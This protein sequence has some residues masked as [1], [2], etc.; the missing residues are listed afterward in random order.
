[1]RVEHIDDGVVDRLF[2]VYE[3]SMADLA[4]G[5]ASA[6]EMRGEYRAFLEEFVSVPGQ[7]VLVEDRDGTWASALRA[8]P[9]G[10]GRWFIEAVETAPAMR[11]R[12]CGRDLLAHTI[13]LLRSLGATELSCIIEPENVA[14]QRLHEGCGFV[15][16]DDAPTNP[17]DEL[18]GGC[19]L[20]RRSCPQATEQ[21]A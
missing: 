12:G 19:I 10:E 20:Y 17:W 1:M 14:S 4:D 18:E 15:A 8:V 5:F 3:E 16:T 6:S 11:N 9:F 21:P 13:D 2:S 7:L